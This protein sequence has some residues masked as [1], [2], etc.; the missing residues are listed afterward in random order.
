M[1][2][3]SEEVAVV[4][5]EMGLGMTNEEGGGRRGDEEDGL[6]GRTK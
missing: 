1:W 3:G 6:Q 2:Q 5:A 4:A